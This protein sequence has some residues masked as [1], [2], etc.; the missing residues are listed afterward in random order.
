MKFLFT[1][2][3]S[4]GLLNSAQAVITF[5]SPTI[6]SGF[7]TG[8]IPLN[9]L[10]LFIVDTG[11]DGFL[12]ASFSGDLLA[13]ADPDLSVQSNINIGGTFGGDSILGRSSVTTAG[14]IP[15]DFTLDNT[16]TYQSKNFA[17]VWFNG[18]TT[19]AT[20]AGAGVTYGIFRGVDWVL[21][22]S[23]AGESFS[24][25]AT[26]ANYD[27]VADVYARVTVSAGVAT[28]D[29]FATSSGP[30]F[31]IVPEPSTTLLGAFGA[32]ALLR[33]RRK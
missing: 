13:S 8:N 7:G 12:G 3:I 19:S 28:N 10:V 25:S 32:L 29:V 31:S 14:T 17:I 15:A 16:V 2:L 6:G 21:P 24:T 20:S 33:R 22:A 1:L 23:N 9:S 11:S 30:I 4:L 18:L 26:F 5:N 27:N